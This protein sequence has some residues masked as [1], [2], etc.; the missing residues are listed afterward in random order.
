MR[1]PTESNFWL[2]PGV[3]EPMPTDPPL[4][5]IEKLL[6]VVIVLSLLYTGYVFWRTVF[7]MVGW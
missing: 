3:L 1:Q 4:T 5:G 7:D 2:A 6:I